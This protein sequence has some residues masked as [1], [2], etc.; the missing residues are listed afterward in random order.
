MINVIKFCE[1]EEKERAV[2]LRFVKRIKKKT[3]A[4]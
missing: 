2:V 1:E 4:V 3:R